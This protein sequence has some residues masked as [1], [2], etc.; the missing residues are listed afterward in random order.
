MYSEQQQQKVRTLNKDLRKKLGDK[1]LLGYGI[2][3]NP[4]NQKDERGVDSIDAENKYI[5]QKEN[6]DLDD[7][8]AQK[9]ALSEAISWNKA[10]KEKLSLEIVE[11][12]RS[13]PSIEAENRDLDDQIAKM[14]SF[15]DP[16]KKQGIV[17]GNAGNEVKQGDT[18]EG[19]YSEEKSVSKKKRV[20]KPKAQ[21]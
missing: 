1:K 9:K 7:V 14:K 6:G 11:E 3:L 12:D 15:K 8:A 5:D 10:L 2:N 4:I 13:L 18:F 17:G 19:T 16:E 21:A 20:R